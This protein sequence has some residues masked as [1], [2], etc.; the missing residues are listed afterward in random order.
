[1]VRYLLGFLLSETHNLFLVFTIHPL[2][3]CLRI[4]H[5]VVWDPNQ[6]GPGRSRKISLY[7]YHLEL[8]VSQEYACDIKLLRYRR[9]SSVRQDGHDN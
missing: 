9:Q 5:R 8:Y 6:N 1:M 7:T 3:G 4:C 2:S